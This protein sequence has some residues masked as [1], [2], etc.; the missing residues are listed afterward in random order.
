IT[1]SAIA[2][3]AFYFLPVLV[4]F[5]AAKR[6]GGDPIV[7]AVIGVVLTYPQLVDWGREFKD[8][9]TIGGFH[10]QFLNY[11]YSIFPMILAAWM[12]KK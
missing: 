5:A 2:D 3:S 11:T 6:V 10:F 9:F 7:T 8:M 12:A 4:G 1:V